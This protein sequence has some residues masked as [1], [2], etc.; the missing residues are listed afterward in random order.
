MKL[1]VLRE[2]VKGQEPDPTFV[3]NVVLVAGGQSQQDYRLCGNFVQ[4]NTRIKPPA[5]PLIDCQSALDGL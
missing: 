5:H 2:V 1:G 3:T 4:P